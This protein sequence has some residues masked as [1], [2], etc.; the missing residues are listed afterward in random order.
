MDTQPSEFAGSSWGKPQANYGILAERR[1]NQIL[2]KLVSFTEWFVIALILLEV[3]LI[4]G[5][6]FGVNFENIIFWDGTSL[7]C[8]MD[9]ATG[10]IKNVR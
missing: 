10:E 7:T 9:G 4:L 3:A 6:V 5:L 2:G 8:M 1:W